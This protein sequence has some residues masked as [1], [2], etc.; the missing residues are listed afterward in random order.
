MIEKG[1]GSE[2]YIVC[3]QPRR[4]AA[5]SIAERVSYE[6]KSSLGDLV[7]YQIRLDKKASSNTRLLYCTTGGEISSLYPENYCNCMHLM[8]SAS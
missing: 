6:S 5:I 2:C 4:I 1:R 7:G 8:S 3:T